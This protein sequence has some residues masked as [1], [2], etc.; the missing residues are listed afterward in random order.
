[1][2]S[3]GYRPGGGRP[4]GPRNGPLPVQ[5]KTEAAKADITPLDYMLAVMR[6]AKADPTRRDRM[7]IAAAPFVHA[8]Q[9]APGRG[10]KQRAEDAAKTAAVGTEWGNDLAILDVRVN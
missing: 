1:M 2:A 3:G 7:A 4:K 8:R 9:D 5:V 6:D 10:K